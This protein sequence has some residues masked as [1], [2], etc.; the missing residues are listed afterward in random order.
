MS[1]RPL[2]TSYLV[3][4]CALPF[5]A[6]SVRG[7]EEPF[8]GETNFATNTK[9]GPPS[10]GELNTNTPG[11]FGGAGR[12]APQLPASL[13]PFQLILPRDHLLGDW[14]GLRSKAEESGFSPTLT[15]VTDIAGNIT[16][17]KNQ[18]VTYADNLGLDLLF[19]LDKLMGL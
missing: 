16:G 10:S 6:S 8:E 3:Q 4:L 11:L 12:T 13:R 17:G 5:L 15:F 1:A 7:Q 2:R 18:G 14:F 9:S 19:D